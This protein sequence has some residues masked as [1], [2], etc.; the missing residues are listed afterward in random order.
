MVHD[1]ALTAGVVIRTAE[2]PPRMG[3]RISA[4]PG[5]H[6]R[7]GVSRCRRCRLASLG[8]AVLPGHRAREPFTDP[9]HRDEVVNG[10]APGGR[11]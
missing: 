7:V 3:F 4:Q 8:G 10:C 5:P 11:A 1:P 6:R 9:H 2:P